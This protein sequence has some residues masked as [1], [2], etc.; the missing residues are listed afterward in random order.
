MGE[1]IL[2][3]IKSAKLFYFISLLV[4]SFRTLVSCRRMSPSDSSLSITELYTLYG[5]MPAPIQQYAV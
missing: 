1:L 3:L 2:L 5:T 4:V